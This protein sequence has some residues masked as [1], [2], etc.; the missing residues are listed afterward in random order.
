MANKLEK[1]RASLNKAQTQLEKVK[2][3]L[4][5]ANAELKAKPE[6]EKLK[7][8]VEALSAGLKNSEE[9]V[10][11]CEEAVKTVEEELK[12]GSDKSGDDKVLENKNTIRL[13]VVSKTGNPTYFRAGL[14]FGK[15]AT[16]V[17]V[18]EDVAS[19]L[20]EDSWLTV[21]EVK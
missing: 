12:S 13:K 19:I 6:D 7:K 11:A 8:K 18:S 2:E 1:A 16:E 10:K 3:A 4:E 20:K 17:E 14:K 15:Q 9:K 5:K 21:E